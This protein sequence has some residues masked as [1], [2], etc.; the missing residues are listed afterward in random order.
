VKSG[1]G[2]NEQGKREVTFLFPESFMQFI[3]Q[4]GTVI[5]LIPGIS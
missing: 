5:I 1:I 2:K 4:P 3:M